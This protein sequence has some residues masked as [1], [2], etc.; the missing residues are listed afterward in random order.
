MNTHSRRLGYSTTFKRQVVDAVVKQQKLIGDTAKEYGVPSRT[1]YAWLKEHSQSEAQKAQ[2]L[3][4]LRKQL[5][6]QLSAVETSMA[7]LN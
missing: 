2:K 5:L 6:D 1:V 3:V 4:Q 7:V